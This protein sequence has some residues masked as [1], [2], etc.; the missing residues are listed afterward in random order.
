M[1]TGELRIALPPSLSEDEVKLL[2]AV[3]LCEVG[4]VVAWASG[5]ASGV[6]QACLYGSAGAISNPR[7]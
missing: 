4:K 2:L 3:K 1:S 7:L 6:F 5:Q